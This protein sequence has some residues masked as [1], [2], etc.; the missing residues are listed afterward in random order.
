[1][2][3]ILEEILNED[4]DFKRLSVFR[5]ILPAIIISTV[6]IACGI[7]G[8]SWFSA[9][10]I[11]HNKELGD[12][13]IQSFT[14]EHANKNK[15]IITNIL[16]E[17]KSGRDSNLHELAAIKIVSNQIQDNHNSLAMQSLEEIVGNKDYSE[18]TKSY[19]RILYITLVID[20]EELTSTQENKAREYLQYFTKETQ[21]FYATASLLKSLFYF[22]NQQFDLAKEYASEVL[23]LSRASIVIKDQAKAII[24]AISKHNY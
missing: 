12:L 14:P 23:K 6:I 24:S 20:V 17:L 10:K 1:M 5:K 18:I 2:T 21:L 19:A 8:Y 16:E 7:A 4:K 9:A 11:K 22:K 13:F 15:K 3:D